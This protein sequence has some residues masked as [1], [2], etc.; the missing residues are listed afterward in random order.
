MRHFAA[1]ARPDVRQAARS[2][3][4]ADKAQNERMGQIVAMGDLLVQPVHSERVL[5]RVILLYAENLQ[6]V[7]EGIVD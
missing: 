4:D 3:R 2:D 7:G 6:S 1:H 5:D